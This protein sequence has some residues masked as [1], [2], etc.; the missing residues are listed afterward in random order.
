[1]NAMIR[2]MTHFFNHLK[3]W[4]SAWSICRPDDYDYS[5]LTDMVVWKL[6]RM[7][8]YFATSDISEYNIQISTT[9]NIVL[10]IIKR[11]RDDDS[12]IFE[13]IDDIYVR[14]VSWDDTSAK[15]LSA[16]QKAY[17][18]SDETFSAMFRTYS[19]ASLCKYAFYQYKLKCTLFKIL[20]EYYQQWW[21]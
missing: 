15:M 13:H 20:K 14:E 19:R 4:F 11:M 18:E 17:T 1:M 5:F 16:W 21:N 3:A 10:D 8:H 2:R 12:Y 7:Q 6:K 9:I